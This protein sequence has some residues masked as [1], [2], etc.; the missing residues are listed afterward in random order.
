MPEVTSPEQEVMSPKQEMD[1][2]KVS[3]YNS[4]QLDLEIIIC[5]TNQ[6]RR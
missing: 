4:Y 3:P 2:S 6:L 5:G 1:D